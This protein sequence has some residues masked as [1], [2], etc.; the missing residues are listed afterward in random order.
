MAKEEKDVAVVA[1][2][3]KWAYKLT[4][5]QANHK[6]KAPLLST[7]IGTFAVKQRVQ[8]EIQ[9]IVVEYNTPTQEEFERMYNIAPEMSNI[10]Q[11]P[12]GYVADWEK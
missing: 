12:I 4:Y 2:P 6:A 3:S 11:P 5:L 9:G 8:K 1:T 10:I 7:T